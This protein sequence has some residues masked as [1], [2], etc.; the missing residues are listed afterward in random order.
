MRNYPKLLSLEKNV[1]T[2]CRR[3]E[4]KIPDELFAQ[5]CILGFCDVFEEEGLGEQGTDSVL[6]DT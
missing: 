3:N 6:L 1:S 2:L 4:H 5:K